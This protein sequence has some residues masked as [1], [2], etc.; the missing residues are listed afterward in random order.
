[1]AVVAGAVGV[2]RTRL[3]SRRRPSRSPAG[4]STDTRRP[5]LPRSVQAA[6]PAARG[7]ERRRADDPDRRHGSA[8]GGDGDVGATAAPEQRLQ[9]PEREQPAPDAPA[10]S[11]RSTARP[12]SWRCSP[13]PC[14]EAFVGARALSQ[15]LRA[16]R[17]G[18]CARTLGGYVPVEARIVVSTARL[19][20]RSWLRAGRT[21]FH[22]LIGIGTATNPTP[23][24]DF[25]IVDR[26]YRLRRSHLRARRLLRPARSRP[27]SPTG[28]A[29][30][31]SGSTER[32]SRT[33]IPGR[34]SHGCIRLR[35][36]RRP[37]A[38]R[39]SSRSAPRSRSA[40]A[41]PA[42]PSRSSLTLLA[43]LR[44]GGARDS[45]DPPAPAGPDAA[46][47]GPSAGHGAARDDAGP[48]RRRQEARSRPQQLPRRRRPGV[49]PRRRRRR[50]GAAPRPRRR[51][52][53]DRPGLP[54]AP[55]RRRSRR[56]EGPASFGRR[57]P[58]AR[59]RGGGPGGRPSSS[60]RPWRSP[61]CSSWEAPRGGGR[62]RG[63]RAAE[64]LAAPPGRGIARGRGR[65]PE[66]RRA[67]RQSA[68][69][70]RRLRG[71][72]LLRHARPLPPPRARALAHESRGPAGRVPAERLDL[73][74]RS[75]GGGRRPLPPV[76]LPRLPL[77]PAHADR[78]GAEGARAGRGRDRRRSDPRR[79]GWRFT[80]D[81]DPIL[82]RDVP[83][84]AY[85]RSD[86][87]TGATS[88]CPCS[89]IGRR[90]G[91]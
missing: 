75:A 79:A 37:D 81:A 69:G 19:Q 35:N 66:R 80:D 20:L 31:S 41:H 85:R 3:A 15:S 33:L 39:A 54:R 9:R 88:R 29:A 26:L 57:R 2:E 27:P 53:A 68:P 12:R 77:G 22:A 1:M 76:R 59:P 52:R 38:W 4:S 17:A 21:I 70:V 24:G 42:D 60:W 72:L 89:G 67:S 5:D 56:R 90:S 47:A 30:G 8:G 36:P 46:L 64:A 84:G 73:P 18:S 6:G 63:G 40:D 7:R 13:V 51:R 16:R 34:V 48:R 32:T 10:H 78:A 11:G 14:A 62:G 25:Y 71:L 23:H 49:A 83:V 55:G 44:R 61:R 28:P 87:G 45:A 50:P 74:R 86:P 43:L 58:R 82:R 91:S 65:G